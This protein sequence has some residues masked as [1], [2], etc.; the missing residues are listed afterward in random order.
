MSALFPAYRASWETDAHRDLRKHAAEFLRKESTPNQ[1]RW[2]AQ[3]QVDR[4]FWNK[5]GDAGLLGLDLPEEYGGAG[6]DFGFSAVV[7]EELALAQDTATGWGVHSPIVAHYINTYGNT[8]Q[9]AR[10]MPGIISGD[11][12]LA[13]AMTEPGT[14]SDLQGVRTSAVRDG[15]H[16]V[17]NGSKTFI[18]NGTH[19]DLLVIVAKTD[20][21]QGAK[22]ISLIVAETKDLPGFERGRVLEKVGQHGQDTRELF[23][24]DMRV[25]VAN[26]LGEEDGQGFIQLMTQL[27]RERLII[28]S[29]NAGMAEA[30]VLESIKYTK[31]RQAFGQPLIKFQNTR[32]QLAELKAEVL[33]IK[34]TVDWCIQNYIDGVNDPA[35]ASMAKLVA[36]DKGVAVVDRCVQF[37]GGYG[38]MMEY[39]IARA[40]AAARVNKIY[41]GTSEIMKEL[42]SR[43][44]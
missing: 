22:G 30:A 3:H 2:S 5:L 15:D 27:A 18:S 8:E 32:F 1:E 41:G 25:P 37:F 29:G 11:L 6:G 20:P 23:F 34:T 26:R 36:T 21:S 28:A 39:P 35:T 43:S 14:G 42:I 10:W 4:E 24:S 31:E 38:Y 44:L 16:Y 7:A 40:Y 13:I 12:V 9:K 33:S 17:I 19:C